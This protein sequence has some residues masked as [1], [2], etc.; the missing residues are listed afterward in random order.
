MQFTDLLGLVGGL[1]L[2]LYGMHMMSEGLE[3]VAGSRLKALLEK[4]TRNRFLGM[5]VG[6]VITA[7]IQSSSATTVMTVGFVNAG[8]MD[9]AQAIG[10]IM[11]ANIGTTVTGLLIAL[12]VSDIAAVIAI[13]GVIMICFLKKKM[14]QHIGM[15]L[16]G[17]GIL[18]IGMGS[19]SDAMAP[20]REVEW[21]QNL[22]VSFRNPLLGIL[23]GALFTAVIQSSSASIGIL[24]ALALQGIIGL[25][26]AVFVLFGQNIGT[27]ITAA[28]ACIGSTKNA[29]RTALVHLSFNVIGTILFT[30]I[31]LVTPFT[32]WMVSLAPGNP[33]AQIA[34]T[35]TVFNITTTLLLLPC[36]NLLAKL[37]HL[38][39]R[40]EDKRPEGPALMHITD[41]S[42]GVS[43]IAMA[44]VQA[45]TTRMERLVRENLDIAMDAFFTGNLT[46]IA[47]VHHNEETIDFLNKEITDALVR[48]NSLE[49]TEHDAKRLGA[50][51]HVVSDLERIGDHAENIADYAR[52]CRER[53][54]TFSEQSVED[55]RA[56]IGMVYQILDDSYAHLM[57]KEHGPE[58]RDIYALEEAID[59]RTEELEKQHIERLNAGRCNSDAGMV[60]VEI[61][62][63]LERVADHALNIAQAAHGGKRMIEA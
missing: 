63:D 20:L 38:I 27:C 37:A 3:L 21:F 52:N 55:L 30:V 51:Y 58:Y 40:G 26:S 41:L 32:D 12:N 9:L 18:F 6:L 24:Q 60:Y 25:D 34:Y 11:G 4:L 1:A 28:L 36:A 44:E 45:E 14:I 42:F 53:K 17:L 43:S 2:F 49:L 8:L 5:L 10:V 59:L 7:V 57:D 19:M 48:I 47:K 35:H 22:M 39:I 29:K 31:A 50:M 62:T 13:A 54:V 23:A 33:M 46:E 61:L 16:A 56:M 15:V